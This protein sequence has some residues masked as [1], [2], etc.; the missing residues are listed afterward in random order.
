M[1]TVLPNFGR[2]NASK[3][4]TNTL[5]CHN[6]YYYG[7]RHIHCHNIAHDKPKWQ[8]QHESNM[9]LIVKTLGT[10]RLFVRGSRVCTSNDPLAWQN[11]A[12]GRGRGPAQGRG[13]GRGRGG[14]GRG[15]HRGLAQAA[16]GRI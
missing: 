12:N 7:E 5:D 2:L 10:N 1:L 9:R 13:Q 11:A 15:A 16:Q 4:K 3:L 8:R 14:G 6:K